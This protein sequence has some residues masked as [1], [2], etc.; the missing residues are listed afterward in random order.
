MAPLAARLDTRRGEAA[1]F[2]MVVSPLRPEETKP[3]SLACCGNYEGARNDAEAPRNSSNGTSQEDHKRAITLALPAEFQ[4]GDLSGRVRNYCSSKRS[5][6]G[7]FLLSTSVE[8]EAAP[9]WFH[10]LLGN[11]RRIQGKDAQGHPKGRCGRR[12][13]ADS[14]SAERQLPAMISGA[15]TRRRGGR[16]RRIVDHSYGAGE[17]NERAEQGP[18]AVRPRSG[19]Y[20]STGRSTGTEPLTQRS[21]S[22]F[23]CCFFSSAS[24]MTASATCCIDSRRSIDVF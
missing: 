4:A 19:P 1:E 18:P 24:S 2:V 17:N 12:R 5:T 13:P 14:R 3:H 7:E 6:F 10:G 11:F 22:P 21:Y 8:R 9:Q 20:R 15:T 23:F 16:P